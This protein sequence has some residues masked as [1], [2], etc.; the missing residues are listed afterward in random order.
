MKVYSAPTEIPVPVFESFQD[1][2]DYDK[3]QEAHVE[4]VKAYAKKYGKG[5]YKGEEIRFP[6]A[7]GY[8]R[9]VVFAPTA[10]IHLEVD[11]AWHFQYTNLLTA[12]ALTEQIEQDKKY[13]A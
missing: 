3:A 1:Y 4:T 11:D 12:K 9:Y 8:A 7:D 5:K 13:K 10:L 6:V 2:H